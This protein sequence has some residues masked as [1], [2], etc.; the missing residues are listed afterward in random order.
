MSRADKKTYHVGEKVSFKIIEL[1]ENLFIV[2]HN[3]KLM[4]V[5]NNTGKVWSVGDKVELVV[6]KVKPLQ[7]SLAA[8]ERGGLNVW[9]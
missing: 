6:Q 3:G 5:Q 9:C 4:R 7:F 2:S 8:S 1:K